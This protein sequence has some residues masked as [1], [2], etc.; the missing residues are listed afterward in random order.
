VGA[1]LGAGDAPL[2]PAAG[3]NAEVVLSVG[4]AAGVVPCRRSAAGVVLCRLGAAW[5]IPCRG[6]APER[7]WQGTGEKF[8]LKGGPDKAPEPSLGL[9]LAGELLS[10]SCS[11]SSTSFLL[12]ALGSRGCRG[13]LLASDTGLGNCDT[14]ERV[15]RI[16]AAVL[17]RTL[18]PGVEA[19]ALG[20]GLARGSGE[21]RLLEGREDAGGTPRE[22]VGAPEKLC[23]ACL[24]CCLTLRA[25][26]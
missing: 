18:L 26:L 22:E 24:S 16:L 13:I 6:A 1:G 7:G 9:L 12:A 23:L 2:V 11:S 8:L 25:V 21:E 14:S 15:D 20:A 10:E 17:L 3:L 19:G 5:V 4:S